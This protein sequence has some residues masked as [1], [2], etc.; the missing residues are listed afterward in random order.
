MKFAINYSPQ[1]EKLWRDGLIR[2][3]LFKCPDWPALVEEVSAIHKLYVHSSLITWRGE[4]ESADFAQLRHWLDTTETAV[5]NTHFTLERADLPADCA[6]GPEAVIECATRA[7]SPL[8]E[9]FGPE[10]VVI[11]NLRH[12]L[13]WEDATLRE[14]VDPAVIGEIA[15]RSG[16]GFLLDIAHAI[17]ACE[18]TGRHDLK[19][20]LNALPAHA[21]RELHVTGI[22]PQAAEDGLR[23]DHFAMTESDWAMTEWALER[24]R[25]GDWRKPEVMAFEYGGVGERFAWR[26]EP[27]VIAEQA[28]RL[29]ALA[30]SV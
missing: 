21:L 22:S 1:A 26:S 6:I 29:Y 17:L 30:K 20:Y 16:C 11:E 12:P 24:I 14:V 10:R 19:A 18:G 25:A 7:L 15:R 5:I 23:H 28:P 4:L 9:R 13:G 3:D 27:A 8:C 2:V